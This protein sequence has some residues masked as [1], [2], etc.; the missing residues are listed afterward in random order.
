MLLV[1][2]SCGERCTAALGRQSDG[3]LIAVRSQEMARGHAEHLM[4]FIS[5]CYRDAESDFAATTA[6]A[7]TNGPGSFTGVRIGLAV[8]RGL[9]AVL[10]IPTIP[11]SM[12]AASAAH[13]AG[14][15]QT[16]PASIFAVLDARR[17][18]A[19]WQQFDHDC[20]GFTEPNCASY[21][22]I[23]EAI[24]ATRCDREIIVC[25]S[26]AVRLLA[27]FGADSSDIT[28]AHQLGAVPAE[29]LV[30]FAS[31]CAPA[32]AAPIYLRNLDAKVQS[33]PIFSQAALP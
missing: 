19:Y 13:A 26:G 7:V 16:R 29:T 21:E 9:A 18:Q 1:I 14:L 10:D 11:I 28:V 15:T 24:A 23:Y 12:L 22:T 3:A 8:A 5:D 32:P 20:I 30:R 6:V 25:G 4:A 27:L 2:D 33:A 31:K 17:E